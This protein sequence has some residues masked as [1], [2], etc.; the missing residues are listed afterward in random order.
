MVLFEEWEWIVG[1][2]RHVDACG[3]GVEDEER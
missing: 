2:W 3:H 1:G